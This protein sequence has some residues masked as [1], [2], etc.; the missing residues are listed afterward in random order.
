MSATHLPSSVAGNASSLDSA[1]SSNPQYTPNSDGSEQEYTAPRPVESSHGPLRLQTNFDDDAESGP[2]SVIDDDQVYDSGEELEG[3][4][5]RSRAAPQYTPEED[6]EVVKLFDRRLVP[7][8]ALLYLL[9]F[10]DR[11]SMSSP[12]TL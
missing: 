12:I 1:S 3:K 8:L 6:R 7:F 11:S 5:T 4:D 10:L 9:A 2:I